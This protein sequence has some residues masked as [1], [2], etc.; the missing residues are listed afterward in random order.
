MCF[1]KGNLRFARQFNIAPEAF[2]NPVITVELR[3]DAAK[4]RGNTAAFLLAVNLLARLFEKV[5]AVFPAAAEAPRHPWHLD[6]ASAVIDELNNT[7]RRTIHVGPP[8]RSDVVLSIGETPSVQADRQTVVYG[9]HWRAALDCD[10]PDAG[11]GVLGSLYAAC[12][13]AAQVL[14][15]V[16]NTLDTHYR[17]MAPFSFSLIDLR[18]NSTKDTILKPIYLPETHLVGVGAVGSAAVYA[19]AHLDDIGGTL[20]LI[21]NDRVDDP[22][23]HRYV[24][25]RRRNIEDWKVDVA[26]DTLRDTSIE[27]DPYPGAFANYAAEHGENI[28]LLLTPVD[29]EEKR[30]ELAKI[31][32]RR[33][34]NA[35]TGGTT[36]TLST[37]GFGDGRACLH[38]LYMPDLNR[39]SPEETMAKDMGLPTAKVKELLRTN[40]PVD[41]ALRAEIGRNRGVEH[42]TWSTD[43]DM[44]ID[45]F[46]VKAVCGEAMLPLPIANVIAPLSFISASAGIL[47]AAELI[48]TGHPELHDWVLDNYF[49]LDT[50]HPP[51][52]AFHQRR[53]PDSSGDCICSDPHYLE[54]FSQ[55]YAT[56]G[57]PD[58]T[59]TSRAW[60]SLI[61]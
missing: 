6:T 29:N 11:E 34:I 1:R 47:L 20:H 14:L 3:S 56:R 5:H 60:H 26:T 48:K 2:S 31:L 36:V 61:K 38:C 59:N 41:A 23:L 37:H 16:L 10:L 42:G 4:R 33:I 28:N 50:L 44:P 30:R 27:T 51:Q 35:A 19:M 58:V 15:H 46:Y 9:T 7:V 54:E 22:N 18:T 39:A 8:T 12:I 21:D 49:R 45:S 43:V 55:K 57:Q 32:P 24:L 40:A 25:M 53:P 17:P 52:S 13:G